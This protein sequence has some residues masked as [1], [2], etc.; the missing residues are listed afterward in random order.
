MPRVR[1]FY[2]SCMFL[3]RGWCTA[4]E[5]GLDPDEGCLTFAQLD[6]ILGE[7]DWEEALFEAEDKEDDDYEPDEWN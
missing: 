1:C 4:D 7:E 5:I 6:E 3:E 2:I